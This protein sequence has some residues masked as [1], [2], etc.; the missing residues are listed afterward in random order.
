MCILL[1]G[2]VAMYVGVGLTELLRCSIAGGSSW[3]PPWCHTRSSWS[4]SRSVCS[5]EH[6]RRDPLTFSSGQYNTQY[7]ITVHL[8]CSCSLTTSCSLLYITWRDISVFL[9]NVTNFKTTIFLL[10]LGGIS[11]Y[12][13][14]GLFR[15]FV[16]WWFL[17]SGWILFASTWSTSWPGSSVT[18]YWS[19]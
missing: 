17:F 14:Q 16:I 1:L 10:R 7:Y 8:G 19:T 3:G 13:Y 4:P 18:G 15:I 2:F 6:W 12:K 9:Q 5:Q 11:N